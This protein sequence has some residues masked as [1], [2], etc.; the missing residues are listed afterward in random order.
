MINHPKSPFD[1]LS[2]GNFGGIELLYCAGIRFDRPDL[3]G[4]AQRRA[5]ELVNRHDVDDSFRWPA[6]IDGQNPGFFAG[7]AGIGYQLL[8]MIYSEPCPSVLLWKS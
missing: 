6:G 5:V 4:L 2:F 3:V 1:A 7:I 8:R